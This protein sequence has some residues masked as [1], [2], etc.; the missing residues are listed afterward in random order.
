MG[1]NDKAN[2]DI[3]S[4]M[5]LGVIPATYLYGLL[6]N[7]IYS[8]VKTIMNELLSTLFNIGYCVVFPYFL[9]FYILQFI[10][11][12]NS[13]VFIDIVITILDILFIP[14]IILGKK[15]MFKY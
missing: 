5:F 9:I 1:W 7:Q 8:W 6:F 3:S 14:F 12:I 10:L 13:Y 4:M 11:K 2:Y 15:I